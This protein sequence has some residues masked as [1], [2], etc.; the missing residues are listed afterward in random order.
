MPVRR[1]P[2]KPDLKQLQRQAKELLRAIHAGDANALAEL[3]EHHPDSIDP[4]AAK[5]ADARLVLA[6]SY[7]ASSWTRLVHAVRLADAIWR[8]DADS[9]RALVTLNA[10]LIH[11]HAL[12]RPDSNWGP[13]MTYAANLGRD[14]IIRL[15]HS[16]GA[17]DVESA[18]GR[19]ALQGKA[20][21]VRMIYDLAGRPELEKLSLAGPAYTLSVEAPTRTYARHYAHDSGKDTGADRCASIATSHRSAGANATTRTSS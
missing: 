9:V 15:L 21:T 2:V 8:D 10:A 11:E 5:L 19:A 7:D 13:P 20:D 16:L 17:R 12:I 18:A 1:L 3:R 6:R 14:R 4:A